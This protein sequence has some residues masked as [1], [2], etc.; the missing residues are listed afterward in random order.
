MIRLVT[1]HDADTAV[2]ALASAFDDDPVLQWFVRQDGGRER[3]K[4]AALR[5][6]FQLFAPLGESFVDDGGGGAALWAA[7]DRWQ[8]SPLRE[9][10]LLPLYLRVCTLRRV[11][12]LVAGF[13]ALERR[14][15]RAPH[16]YLFLLGVRK[17]R[18]GTGLG[19]ALLRPML[20]RCDAEGVGAYLENSKDANLAFYRRHGF[21]VTESF[22][23]GPG[24]P[25]MWAMWREPRA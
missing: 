18:Q 12:R 23:F 17:E 9:L 5:N 2:D 8:L 15:P 11:P 20:E 25:T 1:P 6:A 4:R 24:G 7:H 14:H 21:E 3:A 10:M 19:S 16:H 22:A 13:K